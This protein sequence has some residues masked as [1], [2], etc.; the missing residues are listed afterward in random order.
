MRQGITSV[1]KRKKLRNM[2]YCLGEGKRI[3][4]REFL[5]DATFITLHP[6]AKGKRLSMYYVAANK[7]LDVRMGMLGQVDYLE[8]GKGAVAIEAGIKQIIRRF[9]TPEL[10][11]PPWAHLHGRVPDTTLVRHIRCTAFG[12]D[13]DAAADGQLAARMLRF[14]WLPNALVLKDHTHA[15]RRVLSRPWKA[16]PA[17][18]DVVCTIVTRKKT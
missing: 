11:A 17:C 15:A 14:K 4:E 18:D 12:L 16:V 13:A 8:L 6:D 5:Y 9:A 1:G 2:L 3:L 7:R 10:F